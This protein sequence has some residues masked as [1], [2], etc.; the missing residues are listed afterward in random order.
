MFYVLVFVKIIIIP[1][2]GRAMS[3]PAAPTPEER[4]S[5][6]MNTT[7]PNYCWNCE[8]N[9]DDGDEHRRQHPIHLLKTD[10]IIWGRC[11]DDGA[12]NI[13]QSGRHEIKHPKKGSREWD[14]P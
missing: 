7:R 11:P 5:R 1:N 12:C 8:R 9:V 4:R 2:G 6:N 10:V 13:D 14:M 3:R